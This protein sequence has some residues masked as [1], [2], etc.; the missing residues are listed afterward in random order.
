VQPHFFFEV[1]VKLPAA[2]EHP[3]APQEFSEPIHKPPF[4]AV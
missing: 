4:Q 3:K 2:H 1:R